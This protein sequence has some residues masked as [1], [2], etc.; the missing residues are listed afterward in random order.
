MGYPLDLGNLG[1]SASILIRP[2][3]SLPCTF[4]SPNSWSITVNPL[5]YGVYSN[6]QQFLE[7]STPEYTLRK[8]ADS[9]ILGYSCELV[10]R[11]VIYVV[12]HAC[13]VIV[14]IELAL[15]KDIA[16][17]LVMRVFSDLFGYVG[18]TLVSGNSSGNYRPDQRAGPYGLLPICSEPG[19]SRCSH[20]CLV[21]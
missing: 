14:F 11:T 12:A 19:N 13:F 8:C 4:V 20:L 5:R 1:Y 3:S 7:H 15:G 6:I 21:Y 10:D 16:N 17:V 9:D 18:T 2:C